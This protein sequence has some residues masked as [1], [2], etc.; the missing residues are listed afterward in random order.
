MKNYIYDAMWTQELEDTIENDKARPLIMEM[1]YKHGLRA[2]EVDVVT[3]WGQ[4]YSELNEEA[5]QGEIRIN[6]FM[7]T[8]DGLPYCQVYVEEVTK[9]KTDY[10]FYS[11]Y[12]EKER[13]RDRQDKRT[14]RSAKISGLM[15]MLD[16]YKCVQDSPEKVLGQDPMWYIPATTSSLIR[17]M[18]KVPD[19][20]AFPQEQQYEVLKA[21]MTGD[22]LT[23][24]KQDEY[25]KL[26]DIW[27]QQVQTEQHTVNK[28]RSMFGNDFYLVIET[29][30]EGICYGKAKFNF[31]GDGL[32]QSSYEITDSFQRVKSLDDVDDILKTALTMFKVWEESN[33]PSHYKVKDK[34]LS[35]N[36][37]YIPDLEMVLATGNHSRDNFGMN[38]LAI[39]MET[40]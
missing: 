15:R 36:T 31:E 29:P 4:S 22:K 16:K 17:R 38:F 25:K 7:L 37:G 14:I 8:L 21:Y 34:L 26:L 10:C 20:P 3:K 30:S 1:F 28:V 27:T 13:G 24:E 39:P 2:Y 9:G 11:P 23:M 18:T 40:E 32:K 6:R 5:Y 33:T 12:F 19:R 35:L